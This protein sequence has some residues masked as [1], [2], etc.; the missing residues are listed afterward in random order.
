MDILRILQNSNLL[1]YLLPAL[2]ASGVLRLT[3]EAIA[4]LVARVPV[5]GVPLS[6]L[7]RVLAGQ[8][9]AWLANHVPKL[10]QTAVL[11]TEEKFSGLAG[12]NSNQ[13]LENAQ[14]E[15]SKLAP[16]LSTE[17]QKVQIHA[18]LARLRPALEAVK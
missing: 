1:H 6:A 9:E 3:S 17:Q 16:G 13:K 14:A 18:A 12:N 8:Y 2:I 10:A 7:V 11:A 15:L 4:G 5:V